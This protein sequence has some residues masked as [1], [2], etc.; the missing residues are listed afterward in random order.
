MENARTIKKL[1]N[2]GKQ[3]LR[4]LI[5][6]SL[7][8]RNSFLRRKIQ[9]AFHSNVCSLDC[10]SPFFRHINL[11][12]S[13]WHILVTFFMFWLFISFVQAQVVSQYLLIWT[14]YPVGIRKKEES[15][16]NLNRIIFTFCGS[17]RNTGHHFSIFVCLFIC[18]S[19]YPSVLLSVADYGAWKDLKNL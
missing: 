2:I 8:E 5:T 10:L 15:I 12:N 6:A 14:H 17:S 18:L 9:W 1:G 11:A 13:F 3:A 19:L 4:Q 7:W 16:K